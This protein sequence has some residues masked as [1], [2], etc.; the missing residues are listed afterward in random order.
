MKLLKI[1]FIVFLM[2]LFLSG[3]ASADPKSPGFFYFMPVV[4][5]IV[6]PERLGPFLG[7]VMTIA[8]DPINPGVLY[9]GTW[10]SG[11]FK[12]SD[13]GQTWAPV[14][15]GLANLLIQTLAVDRVNPAYVYA[16]TYYDSTVYSGV[17]RS[18][19]G[20]Q[21][22]QPGGAMINTYNGAP[23][24]RPVVYTLAAVPG[25]G[26]LVYAGTRM[27][28]LVPGQ[29][30]YGG[31][32]VFKSPDHGATWL[33]A[34]SGLPAEDLY[35]YDLS[36]DPANPGRVYAAMHVSGAY[37]SDT[38]ADTWY[39]MHP[40]DISGRVIG[41][42]PFNPANVY[43]GVWHGMG[44]F[45]TEDRGNQWRGS[46]LSGLRLDGLTI[47]PTNSTYVYASTSATISAIPPGLYR[48]S[49]H[50]SSWT[51]SSLNQSFSK[52]AVD[53]FDGKIVYVGAGYSGVQ[54]SSDHGASW[55]SSTWGL[56]GFSVTSVAANPANPQI[57]YSALNQWGVMKSYDRGATWSQASTGLP[58]LANLTRL[59][60]DPADPQVLYAA[61]SDAGVYVT[62]N[63]GSTWAQAATGYPSLVAGLQVGGQSAASAADVPLEISDPLHNRP[64]PALAQ[65]DL[66]VASESQAAAGQANQTSATSVSGLSLA[67]SPATR[68]VLVGTLGRGVMR[69][70]GASWGPTLL[71]TGNVYVLRFDQTPKKVFAGVDAA[72]GSLLVSSDDGLSWT[73]SATGLSGRTVYTISQ[74]S[75]QASLY[76]AGTD[77][78]LYRSE[79]GGVTWA[80]AGL[81]GQA[82]T[83]VQADL[84]MVN[85]VTAG[86]PTGLYSSLDKGINW[87]GI[88]AALN[89]FGIQQILPDP[90]DKH[91]YYLATRFGGTVR[92]MR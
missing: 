68:A 33:P 69:L 19:T 89:N 74:S 45:R 52:A 31:G 92:V 8:T 14:N 81:A 38:A 5:R 44:L 73:A 64:A 16:G 26:G 39:N 57:L 75:L 25:V 43:F 23:V 85:A 62:R 29:A 83:A 28:D 9:A 51:A 17:Y 50:G 54:R 40:P 65:R 59:V 18:K 90:A 36:V 76:Y 7:S 15:A 49:D 13:R 72:K 1:S 32:G 60:M 58:A 11:I 42:D 20:G 66:D 78:G 86:T 12:S 6:P 84:N 67:V 91:F 22:W 37:A 63:G 70:T 3:R 34:N 88:E 2:V 30:I 48:S 21:A 10:G 46:G 4:E 55:A 56:S 61:T 79:D 41:V 87:N 77:S 47:D 27:K 53:P 24:N 35:V 71:N 80:A 82:V